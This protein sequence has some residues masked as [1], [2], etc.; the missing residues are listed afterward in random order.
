M[1]RIS[2][3]YEENSVKE[4]EQADGGKEITIGRAPGCSIHLDEGSVSR[5]HA[6]IRFHN[7][8]WL[9]ER[10]AS[11]GA[12]LLNGQEVE[13]APL[14]GGEEITVGKFSLRVNLDSSQ[15]ALRPQM[16]VS[17]GMSQEDD[18]RTRLVSTGVNA[19]LRFEPGSANVSEFLMQSDVAVFGRGSNCDVVLTEKK[20]SR[21]HVEIR[22]QGMSFFVKDL[23]SANGTLLNGSPVNEAELVAGDVIQIGEAK[24][25]FSVENKDYF[26]GQ[27]NFMP[28]PA[29]AQQPSAY[30]QNMPMESNY[31]YQQGADASFAAPGAQAPQAAREPEPQSLVGKFKKWYSSLPKAQRMRWL[32]ILVVIA[33]VGAVLGGPDEAPKPKPK[34]TSNQSASRTFDQLTTQKKKFV[35]EKYAN[36]LKAHDVRDFAK[37]IDNTSEILTYVD[38]YKDTKAYEKIAKRGLEEIEEEKSRRALEEKQA[39]I[40][41]EVAAL[42]EKGKPVFEKAYEDRKFRAELDAVIQEIY[43]KDPNNQLALQWKTRI[44]LKEEE[45]KREAELARQKEEQK[46]KAE[47]ALLAV[48]EIFQQEKYILATAEAVKLDD[49]G[50]TDP[51]YLARVS[52]LKEEIR[53]KLESVIS[54]LL[55]DASSQRQ[56]GGDLVKANEL[57]KQVLK[58]DASNKEARSGIDAIRETLH[59]RAKRF[60]AE[61][62]L[63]ESISELAEAKDKYEKCLRVAPDE[64]VYKRRCRNKL[65]RFEAFSSGSN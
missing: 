43:A 2:V 15:Q 18:G 17:S 34:T 52:G 8:G 22:R 63:A 56:E 20:A 45:E 49:S 26:S 57:Y 38:D 65:S 16:T 58:V 32:T 24:I 19:L 12:V 23:N 7:G 36:L 11:F 4:F 60:Y 31:G 10:K 44:K 39:A 40:R 1:I 35:V 28:V 13:N 42:E 5:L 25:Q 62:I 55:K 27:D 48:R 30:D 3:Y 33:L 37:M 53:Q 9:L 14:E 46:A 41:R 61:A 21:K 47:A 50:W 6:L 64:D 29:H 59:L 54:P 51:D